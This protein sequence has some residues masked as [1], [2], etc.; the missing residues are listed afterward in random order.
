MRK[1]HRT[2]FKCALIISTV[3]LCFN[4]ASSSRNLAVGS[5]L[6][7][8][9][10]DMDGQTTTAGGKDMINEIDSFDGIECSG[11]MMNVTIRKGDAFG[12]TLSENTIGPKVKLNLKDNKLVI[13]QR[14]GLHLPIINTA[15]A[16][17]VTVYVPGDNTLASVK[18][19]LSAGDISLQ[20]IEI[21][22][23]QIE[24]SGGDVSLTGIKAQ[25]SLIESSSGNIEDQNSDFY[26]LEATSSGGDCEFNGSVIRKGNITSSGGDVLLVMPGDVKDYSLKLEASGGSIEFEGTEEGSIFNTVNDADADRFVTVESSGGDI[27]VSFKNSETA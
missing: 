22:K 1:K 16:P 20:N 27:H 6:Q 24:Q 18:V 26:S 19:S 11:S 2:V 23:L 4:F 25:S 12:Y 13:T 14:N 8:E 21:N 5:T 9:S 17:S 7:T 3:S 10:K 15:Y